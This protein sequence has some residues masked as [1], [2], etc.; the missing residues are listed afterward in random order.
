MKSTKYLWLKLIGWA[1]LCHIILISLSFIEVFI[2]SII[3]NPG[4]EESIYTEH[5]TKSAPYVAIILG[6]FL[7]YLVARFLA[8][9]TSPKRLLIALALP[10]LYVVIDLAILI[11]FGVDWGEH[12]MVFIL[13]FGTKLIFAM[14]GAFSVRVPDDKTT[15]L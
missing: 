1:L 14:I 15:I 4:Q 8:K 11:P 13:S 3:V 5:A 10:V 12:F 7:F 6:I 9:K 2:Y